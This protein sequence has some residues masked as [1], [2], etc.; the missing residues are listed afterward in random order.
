MQSTINV[1][2]VLVSDWIVC[3]ADCR[4]VVRENMYWVTVALLSTKITNKHAIPHRKSRRSGDGHIFRFGRTQTDR[5]L[6]TAVPCHKHAKEISTET[7]SAA[8][9][10]R[11]R[12]VRI[13]GN[14]NW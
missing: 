11:V 14:H 5:R 2:A 6:Q 12:K 9:I 8:A 13:T 1:P 7:S 4:F 3:D 10:C